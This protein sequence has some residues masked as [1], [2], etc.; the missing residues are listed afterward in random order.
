MA[1]GQNRAW[2]GGSTRQ[3]R[4]IRARVLNRDGH[5][6]TIR[7]PRCTITATEVDHIINKA[8]GG[9]DTLAN[10]RAVCQSCHKPITQQ[11]ATAARP[12]KARPAEAHP[13]LRRHTPR[14]DTP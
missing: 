6:C 11:Q 10:L 2:A 8:A 12:I 14:G 1:W 4:T 9:T 3:W 7:G 13:A 5:E